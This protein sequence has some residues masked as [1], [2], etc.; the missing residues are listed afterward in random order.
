MVAVIDVFYWQETQSLE[1]ST[2]CC[3]AIS[4]SSKKLLNQKNI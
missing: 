4:H 1:P 2:R 3:M